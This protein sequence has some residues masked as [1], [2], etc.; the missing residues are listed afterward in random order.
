MMP[1]ICDCCQFFM[2]DIVVYKY[3]GTIFVEY[4][5]HEC[6]TIIHNVVFIIISL[7]L[8]GVNFSIW[9][10]HHA[11]VAVPCLRAKRRNTTVLL[12]GIL[13]AAEQ[14]CQRSSQTAVCVAVP[15]PVRYSWW[16]S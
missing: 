10:A 16:S 1:V 8:A 3:K 15:R 9:K 13:R 2:V 4:P 5:L 7:L 6:V 14:G 11:Q 12:T